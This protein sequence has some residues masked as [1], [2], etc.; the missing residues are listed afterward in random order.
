MFIAFEGIDGSGKSV[1]AR[2]L[3][4]RLRAGGREVVATREPGGSDGAEEIR[5]LLVEGATGRWSPATEAL[6]YTAA[7]RDH[8]ERVI[9]PA[10]ERGAWVVCDRF[11]DSTRAYQGATRGGRRAMVDALHAL[12][13]GREPDRTILIDLAPE[14]A[15]ER[16][17]SRGGSEDRFER[18]G[19]AFQHAVRD[20]YLA[21]AR[22]AP[23]RVRVIDGTGSVEAVAARVD[24][25]IEAGA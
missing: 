15:L 9:E 8:L 5:R 3:A 18:L 25:A 1:Q 12:A 24:A 4:E 13:I 2:R 21:I 7:R 17:L 10:L 16:G 11:A 6:L 19:L 14:A 22:D 23:S 20:A